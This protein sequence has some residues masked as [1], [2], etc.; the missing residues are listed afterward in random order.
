MEAI[1]IMEK[2]PTG[3]SLLKRRLETM[4]R[5]QGDNLLREGYRQGVKRYEN[6]YQEALS[7]G[8]IPDKERFNPKRFHW[9][10]SS[11]KH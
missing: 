2:D 10:E 9:W 6:L 3:L 8:A 4:E 11:D 1:K 5:V 7:Y